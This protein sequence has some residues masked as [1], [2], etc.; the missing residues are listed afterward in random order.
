MWLL[1]RL[2]QQTLFLFACLLESFSVQPKLACLLHPPASSLLRLGLRVCATVPV[3]AHCKASHIAH[4]WRFSSFSK[5]EQ[6]YWAIFWVTKQTIYRNEYWTTVV[7]SHSPGVREV[8]CPVA[9]FRKWLKILTAVKGS[10][11]TSRLT[12][13]IEK[14]ETE[15][16]T[17]KPAGSFT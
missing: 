3:P 7:S 5:L 2:W 4:S 15:L 1:K 9:M 17:Q 13:E 11:S 6:V 10:E 8:S 12:L 14:L 16:V